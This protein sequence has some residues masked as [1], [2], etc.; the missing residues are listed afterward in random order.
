MG[1]RG[2]GC[3]MQLW[4]WRFGIHSWSK[5]SK[6]AA[7]SAATT[8]TSCMHLFTTWGVITSRFATYAFAFH[9]RY[10]KIP[11]SLSIF[12]STTRLPNGQASKTLL[13]SQGIQTFSLFI[14]LYC[15]IELSL[16][17]PQPVPQA[18]WHKN[19]LSQGLTGGYA[20]SLNKPRYDRWIRS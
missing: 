9:W 16:Q 3:C 14:L 13:P 5:Q 17:L 7:T 15:S 11:I 2:N 6:P 10:Q 4:S 1:A 18:A 12:R 20:I 8:S 19:Y